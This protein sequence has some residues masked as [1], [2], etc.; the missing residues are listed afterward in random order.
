MHPSRQFPDHSLPCSDSINHSTGMHRPLLASISSSSDT[1]S[2][3]PISSV[4]RSFQT[5]SSDY[6][7]HPIHDP[8]HRFLRRSDSNCPAHLT[9]GKR[10][11]WLKASKK[12]RD[13]Q[14]LL[15]NLPRFHWSTVHYDQ[16][17]WIHRLQLESFIQETIHTIQSVR[18]FTIDTESDR[19]TRQHPHSLPALLQIQSIH[20][21]TTSTVFLIEVQHLP[22]PSSSLFATIRQLCR[23]IFTAA[24]KIMAWGDVLSELRPFDSFG[25]F[26]LQQVTNVR[27]LQAD[28]AV[29]WNR[30]HPH[31]QDCLSNLARRSSTVH[32]SLELICSVSAD[33]LD[34]DIQPHSIHD[35]SPF[36]VCP[37]QLR[38]Y[39]L[40][41]PAWS[42]QRAVEFTLNVALD[43]AFTMNIWSCGIDPKLHRSLS[44]QDSLTR[45]TMALY[46]MNDVFAPTQLFIHFHGSTIREVDHRHR[47]L[48]R[49]AVFSPLGKVID[50]QQSSASA[51]TRQPAL[52]P[53]QQSISTRCISSPTTDSS[54]I[55]SSVFLLSDS[56]GQHLPSPIIT[57][58]HCLTT[59][60][61]SGLQWHQPKDRLLC[62]RSLIHSASIVP[63]IASA[64]TLI[65]LVGTNSVRCQFAQS[66]IDTISLVV[67]AIRHEHPHLKKPGSIVITQCFPCLRPSDL[68]QTVP[69]LT[70]NIS[71]YNTQ[72]KL[73]GARLAFD[74][75]DLKITHRH[76]GN[77]K[78]HVHHLS[79][80]LIRDA[81]FN[82]LIEQH[83]R[84]P[85]SIAQFVK[86]PDS[87]PTSFAIDQQD[88]S[89][90]LDNQRTS[91]LPANR[92]ATSRLVVR[93]LSSLLDNQPAS[94]LLDDGDNSMLFDNRSVSF[95]PD[96]NN[97]SILLGDRQFFS[98]IKKT[99]QFLQS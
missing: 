69:S 73:L 78:M 58:H 94:F 86:Q 41:N 26:D 61:T 49:D 85:T 72:L 39:K 29:Q 44:P 93:Q 57:P 34:E 36:C 79:R 97:E 81:L 13:N 54:S 19:P 77:D 12:A 7:R 68:F 67:S 17:I 71:A 52:Y 25:L 65:F 20:D 89:L 75:V 70:S 80:P 66:I 63:L 14:A 92:Q 3:P 76:L 40:R 60:A 82:Y 9:G 27:N 30:Q 18:L 33:D 45:E 15:S 22:P 84:Q 16:P 37:I 90:L 83:R 10:T 46:A 98:T 8:H 55:L 95:R 31:V 87:P 2:R 91:F 1:V 88:D 48:I 96:N 43:K 6:M 42:L 11:N 47:E 23:T 59:R 28:F 51:T 4:A 64:S 74:V 38:P 21:A 53:Q 99:N 50:E 5:K 32:H 35:D 62:V 56:H 24:N